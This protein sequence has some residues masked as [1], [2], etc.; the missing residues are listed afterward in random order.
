MK[1]LATG[2]ERRLEGA[3]LAELRATGPLRCDELAERVGVARP[4]V[5]SALSGLA[6]AGELEALDDDRIYTRGPAAGADATCERRE[7]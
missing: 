6:A 4:L 7:R 2:A 5:R 3:V 1:D